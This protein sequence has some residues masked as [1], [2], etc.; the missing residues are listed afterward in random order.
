VR[1]DEQPSSSKFE[2]EKL[3]IKLKWKINEDKM[4][5]IAAKEASQAS[6][7]AKPSAVRFNETVD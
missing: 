4:K 5:Q 7:T 1:P 6:S 3:D 2:T